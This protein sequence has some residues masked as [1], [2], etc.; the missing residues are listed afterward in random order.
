MPLPGYMK[1]DLPKHIRRNVSCFRLQAHRLRVETARF[2]EGAS[3]V[4]DKCGAG[5]VQDEKHVLFHCSCEQVCDVR[6]KY[7]DLFER[8]RCVHG[9]TVVPFVPLSVRIDNY[10]VSDFLGQNSVRL[11]KCISDIMTVFAD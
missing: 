4:C 10:A 9:L 6:A 7:A 1:V 5:D 11:F 2:C 8:M 3:S